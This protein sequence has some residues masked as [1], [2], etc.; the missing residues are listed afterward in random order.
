MGEKRDATRKSWTTVTDD[1]ARLTYNFTG[2]S[3]GTKYF[4]RVTAVNATG[5]GQSAE[6]TEAVVPSEEPGAPT[7]VK[8]INIT[9]TTVTLEWGK[10]NYDGGKAIKEYVIEYQMKET[11]TWTKASTVTSE[12]TQYTVESLETGK[13][14]L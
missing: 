3:E 6:T 7:F 13:Q 12:S 14:Y 9:D 4:F 1:W 10:P 5:E 2:L 11:E 8:G